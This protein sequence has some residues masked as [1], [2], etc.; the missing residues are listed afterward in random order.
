[1]FF[2][3]IYTFRPFLKG[4]VFLDPRGRRHGSWRRGA[5]N[6]PAWKPAWHPRGGGSAPQILA[7][8]S[9]PRISAPS[10]AP[11]ILA[12]SVLL[13]PRALFPF[14]SVPALFFLP[15]RVFSPPQVAQPSDSSYLTVKILISFV[16]RQE[17]G[18]LSHLL[19]LCV[20]I[21]YI[22]DVFSKCRILGFRV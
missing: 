1:M 15:S 7:P 6:A 9:A 17:Q 11:W 13:L 12:P 5:G 16:D 18:I 20:L 4:F 14:P 22:V 10:S 2:L 19:N 3:K 8:S 21:W